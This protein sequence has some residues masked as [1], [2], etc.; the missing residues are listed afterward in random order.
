MNFQRKEEREKTKGER[1]KNI[2]IKKVE[3]KELGGELCY[4]FIK[5]TI[6]KLYK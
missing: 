5:A 4:N 2:L 1:E 3:E 6:K